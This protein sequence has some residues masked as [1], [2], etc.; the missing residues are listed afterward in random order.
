MD[1]SVPRRR[2]PRSREEPVS[3]LMKPSPHFEGNPGMKPFR[4]FKDQWKPSEEMAL[5]LS[6]LN[7]VRNI[8]GILPKPDGT[9]SFIWIKSNGK[10]RVPLSPGGEGR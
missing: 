1:S 8:K 10:I 3:F 4:N 9:E 5:H 6:I 7:C 2:R